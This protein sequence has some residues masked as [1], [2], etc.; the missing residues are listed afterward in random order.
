MILLDMA[1]PMA[2]AIPLN[3][4]SPYIVY[5]RTLP[6][7]HISLEELYEQYVLPPRRRLVPL[8]SY[9]ASKENGKNSIPFLTNGHSRKSV[10]LL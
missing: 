9:E 6:K 3:G 10:N 4:G 7:G 5:Q 2:S 1:S 8:C